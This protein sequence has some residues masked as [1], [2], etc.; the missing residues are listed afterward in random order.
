MTAETVTTRLPTELM[1]EIE[2]TSKIEHLGKSA[3]IRRLL[4][5]GLQQWRIKR[6]MDEYKQGNLSF[7]QATRFAKVSVWKFSDLM[8]VH[9]VP[10]QL[11]E[12]DIRK[13]FKNAGWL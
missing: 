8:K 1:R 4:A 3:I 13:E 6:A 10:L 12:E 7:G 11:D 9:K 5:D 2:E